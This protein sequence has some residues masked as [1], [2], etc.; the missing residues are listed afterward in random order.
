MKKQ[1]LLFV[2]ALFLTIAMHTQAQQRDISELDSIA[3]S[4][5]NQTT[6]GARASVTPMRMALRSSQVLKAD[7]LTKREAFYIYTPASGSEKS[8]VIVSGDERMPA[9]L[10]YS[11]ESAF[12]SDSLPEGLQWYLRKC[13]HDAYLLSKQDPEVTRVIRARMTTNAQ[14]Q[15]ITS[16]A[17][18]LGG[19]IWNQG[20][21]FNK[22]CPIVYSELRSV[23]GCVATAMAQI[24]AYHKYPEKGTGHIHYITRTNELEVNV[25]LDDEAPYD[26][27]NMLDSYEDRFSYNSTQANAVAQLMYHAGAAA[28]MNYGNDG[29]GATDQNALCGLT[30]SLKYDDEIRLLYRTCF[31]PNEWQAILYNELIENRPIYY[32]GSSNSILSTGHAFVL[33]GINSDGLFH[34]NWGWSGLCNGY[35]SLYELTP[36]ELGI[37]AGEHGDYSYSNAAIVNIKP[38]NGVP[39]SLQ[40]NLN[41]STISSYHGV[42]IFELNQ[43]IRISIRKL[44]NNYQSDFNG[45]VQALLMDTNDQFIQTLGLPV[46]TILQPGDIYRSGTKYMSFHLPN[47]L[48]DGNYRIYIG[49]QQNGSS[50]WEIVRGPRGDNSNKYN[51]FELV[52]KA[53]QYSLGTGMSPDDNSLRLT[54]DNFGT[55][56]YLTET[57]SRWYYVAP[58]TSFNTV[59]YNEGNQRFRGYMCMLLVEK[60]GNDTIPFAITDLPVRINAGDFVERTFKDVVPDTLSNGVYRL[61]LAAR[62]EED[63]PWTIVENSDTTKESYVTL[64]LRDSHIRLGYNYEE[65]E[66]GFS[67]ILSDTTHIMVAEQEGVYHATLTVK[68]NFDKELP[69]AFY[70]LLQNQDTYEIDTLYRYK[71]RIIAAGET[72]IIPIEVNFPDNFPMGYYWVDYRLTQDDSYLFGGGSATYHLLTIDRDLKIAPEVVA[73][74]IDYPFVKCAERTEKIEVRAYDIVDL[75]H[76]TLR[77]KVG[78]VVTDTCHNVVM[79]LDSITS[80]SL[81]STWLYGNIPTDLPDGKYYLQIGFLPTDSTNWLLVN[82]TDEYVTPYTPLFVSGNNYSLGTGRDPNTSVWKLTCS[83]FGVPSGLEGTLKRNQYEIY[84][85][86]TTMPYIYNTGDFDFDGIFQMLITDEV[87][88]IIQP[89]GGWDYIYGILEPGKSGVIW[90]DYITSMKDTIPNIPNGKYQI[91]L[92]AQQDGEDEWMFVEN[93]EEGKPAYITLVVRDSHIRL[94]QNYEEPEYGFS[95]ILENTCCTFVAGKENTY[96]ATLKISNHFDKALP[97][98]CKAVLYDGSFNADTMFVTSEVKIPAGETVSVPISFAIPSYIS[99]GTY[100]IQYYL[101]ADETLLWGNNQDIVHEFTIDGDPNQPPYVVAEYIVFEEME[102]AGRSNRITVESDNLKDIYH[103]TF[104]GEIAGV[105][106]DVNDVVIMPLDS[107]YLNDYGYIC[108]ISGLIPESL[109]NGTYRLH[110]GYKA[111]GSDEWNLVHCTD[112]SCVSYTP[113]VVKDSHMTVGTGKE[114]EHSFKVEILEATE[115][116]IWDG[117]YRAKL[118]VTNTGYSSEFLCFIDI[119]RNEG[120]ENGGWWFYN[121]AEIYDEIAPGETKVLDIDLTITNE[122]VEEVFIPGTYHITYT[123]FGDENWL[124]LLHD[125]DGH[126]AYHKI[127]LK[128][129][130]Q[131]DSVVAEELIFLCNETGTVGRA[132]S[133]CIEA[134]E[135]TPFNGTITGVL[136]DTNDKFITPLEYP[137]ES[138]WYWGWIPESLPNGTYRL[139]LGYILEG[140]EEWKLVQCTSES[141]M[142]YTTI[143]V[144]DSHMTIGTGTPPMTSFKVKVLEADTIVSIN[145]EYKAKLSVTN[146][147]KDPVFCYSMDVVEVFEDGYSA[148]SIL[149][150]EYEDIEPNKTKIIEISVFFDEEWFADGFLQFGNFYITYSVGDDWLSILH[151]GEGHYTYHEIEFT[152]PT[153]IDEKTVDVSKGNWATVRQKGHSLIL[154][155]TIDL[156]GWEIIST[157]GSVVAQSQVDVDAGNETNINFSAF[158]TGIYQLRGTDKGGEVHVLKFVKR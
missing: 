83:D 35:Y 66:Y 14:P 117:E 25:N 53:G 17:P 67:T 129:F 116:S 64:V 84:N 123:Y 103:S 89:L 50:N 6:A 132:H 87:G 102:V 88:N 91:R 106:T 85:M 77:G 136:T 92:G 111:E 72:V 15:N 127:E 94:G 96:T 98:S 104:N 51:Y 151:D 158:P 48:K 32:S 109:S 55:I 68:N 99:M 65:P 126:Y 36:E 120:E 12:D 115:T 97:F 57:V 3:N 59:I 95:T 41:A 4:V 19:R 90:M 152:E 34:I 42:G 23:T 110:L 9:V 80:E 8:F 135:L 21:P 141:C 125:G 156:T 40:T 30:H 118:S 143:V 39:N 54:A 63:K 29:S 79:P 28:Q 10:G 100:S 56:D 140:Q 70:G 43:E 38:D 81:Y 131:P 107:T 149:W 113:L 124:S 47:D 5:F 153:N 147:G 11:T 133:I 45:Y 75:N 105:I 31:N 78:L 150:S 7:S 157:L 114:P 22:Q 138:D 130:G 134:I 26:W 74:E 37:G 86:D 108:Y 119:V 112:E 145:G 2:S 46:D 128:E 18:L 1:Y 49:A 73:D 27:D 122:A 101:A 121:L 52:V 76:V 146:T 69:F 33:D 142:P 13:E 139:Y 61:Y 71:E 137:T 148:S 155:T 154:N 62:T 93:S 44:G 144:K 20:D 16:V 24:M 60:D 58:T 82:C